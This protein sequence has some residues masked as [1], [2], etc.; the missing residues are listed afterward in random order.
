MVEVLKISHLKIPI[1]TDFRFSPKK[2]GN[3]VSVFSSF[4]LLFLFV[5]KEKK[6]EN[7]KMHKNGA[8][9]EMAKSVEEMKKTVEKKTISVEWI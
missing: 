9:E 4:F 5:F 2:R 8:V 3:R 7:R 6:E 1:S